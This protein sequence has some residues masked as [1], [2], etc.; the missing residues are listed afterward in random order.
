MYGSRAIFMVISCVWVDGSV[1]RLV[2]GDYLDVGK[3]KLASLACSLRGQRAVTTLA[4][5]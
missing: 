1:R 3:W 2:S 5:V 4:R